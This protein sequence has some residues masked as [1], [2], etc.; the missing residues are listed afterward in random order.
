VIIGPAPL[1]SCREVEEFFELAPRVPVP[2]T[3]QTFPLN[4]ANEA[5]N[6]LRTGQIHGTAEL[7]LG[8]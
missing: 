4:E 1:R 3:V 2:T 8:S 6:S 7:V 5:L